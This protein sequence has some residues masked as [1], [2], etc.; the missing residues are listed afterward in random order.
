M[1]L[2]LSVCLSPTRTDF[3][4]GET[5]GGGGCWRPPDAPGEDQALCVQQSDGLRVSLLLPPGHNLGQYTQVSRDKR[6]QMCAVKHASGKNKTRRTVEP[7]YQRSKSSGLY[8]QPMF[9]ILLLSAVRRRSVVS[10]TGWRAAGGPPRAALV[11]I[12]A[13]RPA[14][15]SA[16]TGGS[17]SERQHI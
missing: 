5:S 4:S 13:T 12:P 16:C 17:G 3:P 6:A 10:A 1:R 9:R 11:Q 14:T 15:G 8:F 7:E 2:F